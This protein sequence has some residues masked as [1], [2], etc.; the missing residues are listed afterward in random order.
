MG[1]GTLAERI[2][3]GNLEETRHCTLD[4]SHLTGRF[5]GLHF[6]RAP[7]VISESSKLG[8]LARE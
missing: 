4:T 5:S 6:S 7:E 3:N 8:R 2:T 1:G